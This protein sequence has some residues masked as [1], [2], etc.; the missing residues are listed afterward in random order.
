MEFLKP[1]CCITEKNRRSDT[2]EGCELK[3]FSKEAKASLQKSTE[4]LT[5]KPPETRQGLFSRSQTSTLLENLTDD[6]IA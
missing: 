1:A 2:K 4:I 3:S 6:A 5:Q